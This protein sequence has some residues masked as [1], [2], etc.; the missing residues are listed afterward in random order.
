VSSPL[1]AQEDGITLTNA[2]GNLYTA[3]FYLDS[4]L[5]D[6]IRHY[7]AFAISVPVTIEGSIGDG[8]QVTVGSCGSSSSSNTM[9]VTLAEPPQTSPLYH[10]VVDIACRRAHEMNGSNQQGIINAI[11]GEFETRNI[12]RAE[13]GPPLLPGGPPQ[14]VKLHYYKNWRTPNIHLGQLLGGIPNNDDSIPGD[15]RCGAWAQL[16]A[17]TLA[18]HGITSQNNI[19]QIWPDYS[20]LVWPPL[21]YTPPSGFMPPSFG[22]PAVWQHALLLIKDWNFPLGI[23]PFTNTAAGSP[24][25]TSDAYQWQTSQVTEGSTFPAQGNLNPL[26]LFRNHIVVRVPAANNKLYDPSYGVIYD[27]INHFKSAAVDGMG[28][29]SNDGT[30]YTFIKAVD[31]PG[32]TVSTSTFPP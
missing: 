7:E 13:R 8:Q 12:T 14:E 4:D 20:G 22:N 32:L 19:Y 2:G 25:Y 17:G 26:S 18:V 27:N 28:Y 31:G 24:P 23:G 30:S 1:G 6:E 29:D 10:T 15:G 3:T 16:F 5:P 11:W 9:Y 21:G